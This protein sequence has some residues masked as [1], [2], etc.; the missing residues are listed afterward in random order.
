MNFYWYTKGCLK[1]HSEANGYVKFPS[2]TN[3]YVKFDSETKEYVKFHSETKGCLKFYYNLGGKQFES[4]PDIQTER[5]YVIF[6][7]LQLSVAYTKISHDC[8]LPPSH[9]RLHKPST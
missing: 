5:V 7:S 8:F 1:F 2:E 6:S 3:G 9:T 4:W